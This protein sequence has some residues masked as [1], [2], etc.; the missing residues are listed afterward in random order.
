MLKYEGCDIQKAMCILI[1]DTAEAG[2]YCSWR[3]VSDMLQV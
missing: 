1:V 2:S 3:S